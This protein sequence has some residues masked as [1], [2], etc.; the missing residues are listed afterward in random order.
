MIAL[1]MILLIVRSKAFHS[2][3]LNTIVGIQELISP[4]SLHEIL[5]SNNF[6]G[7]WNC[8]RSEGK[9]EIQGLRCLNSSIS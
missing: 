8:S 9:Q 1:E 2:A 7:R 6:L 3:I 5:L 4:Y